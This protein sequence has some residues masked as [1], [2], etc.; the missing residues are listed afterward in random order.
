MYPLPAKW[1]RHA[2][3]HD[4]VRGLTACCRAT[5]KSSCFEPTH[6]GQ[7]AVVLHVHTGAL[8]Q[9]PVASPHAAIESAGMGIPQHT[10]AVSGSMVAC[11]CCR[12]VHVLCGGR[13]PPLPVPPAIAGQR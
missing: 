13:A 1:L 7:R 12:C 3:E 5:C 6:G 10:L 11:C 9:V 2:P 8:S 4:L